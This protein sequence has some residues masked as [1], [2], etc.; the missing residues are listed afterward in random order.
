MLKEIEDFYFDERGLLVFTEKY[1][2][3]RG[4]CCQM[5]CRHCP[6]QKKRRLKKDNK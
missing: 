3:K 2:L 5:G 1:L 4:F 6:W